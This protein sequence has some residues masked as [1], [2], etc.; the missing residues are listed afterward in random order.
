MY[1]EYDPFEISSFTED[2]LN[3]FI[4]HGYGDMKMYESTCFMTHLTDDTA[5]LTLQ[6]FYDQAHGVQ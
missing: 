4:N 3:V 1:E 5:C 2:L 6:E